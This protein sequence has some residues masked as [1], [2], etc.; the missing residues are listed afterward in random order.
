MVEV[1]FSPCSAV[2]TNWKLLLHV[3]SWPWGLN[4][5]L[6]QSVLLSNLLQ[7]SLPVSA[8]VCVP[9]RGPA[10]GLLVVARLRHT[11]RRLE[12]GPAGP[13]WGHTRTPEAGGGPAQP[14][15]SR[16]HPCSPVGGTDKHTGRVHMRHITNTYPA[17]IHRGAQPWRQYFNI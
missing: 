13:D 15:W 16:T 17:L 8:P 3:W 14:A 11:A 2:N 12:P 5:T 4:E 6:S 1:N 10:A 9:V 7:P